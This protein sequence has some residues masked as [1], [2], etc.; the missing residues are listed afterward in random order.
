MDM[1]IITDDDEVFL[2][3]HDIHVKDFIVSSI[4]L[5]TDYSQIEGRS[6]QIDH[7][8]TYGVR[9]IR[10]PFYIDN[11][12]NHDFVLLRDL[13]FDLVIKRKSF[14]IR[15][16]RRVKRKQYSFV[17]INESPKELSGTDNLHVGGKRYLVRLSNEFDIDQ[18]FS[19][20]EGELEFETTV[21]PFAESIRTSMDIERNG[22]RYSDEL[23]GYG[24]GLSHNEEEW[25]YEHNGSSF[26]VYNAGIDV[27][28]FEQEL[29]IT[30]ENASEGYELKNTTTGDTFKYNGSTNGTLVLGGPNI[31][32][33][34]LQAF[35]DTNKR[36]ITLAR[37]WN[38]FTQNQN[39][40]VQIDTRF[41]YL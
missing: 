25:K 39:R 33:N 34:G 16:M 27:H 29:K 22:I 13:L 5:L 20:G 12:D 38:Q 1:Q 19:Y 4:S 10:V 32:M 35:R 37:G 3:D 24:M 15:E 23:W 7:G 40:K 21:L 28:P 30:I 41:Y 6:G 26:R 31:T 11:R 2:S 8:S 18:L 9:T 17:D 36:Y 14:Y